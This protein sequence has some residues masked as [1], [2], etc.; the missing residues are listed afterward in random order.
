MYSEEMRR[1]ALDLWFSML[2]TISVDDFVAELGY[3]SSAA[4]RLLIRRDPRH[5]PD[6]LTY[7]SRPVLT[8]LEAIRC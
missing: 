6:T 4:M 5:D 8:K 7:R 2:G 1:E 3:P